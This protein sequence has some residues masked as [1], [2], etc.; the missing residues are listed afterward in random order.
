MWLRY[1]T[2]LSDIN[3]VAS[4]REELNMSTWNSHNDAE[5]ENRSTQGETFPTSKHSTTNPTQ[6]CLRLKQVP[7]RWQPATNR[8]SQARLGIIYPLRT[9]RIGVNVLREEVIW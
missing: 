6:I 9:A 7:W 3:I 5:R 4:V 2:T 1:L 8:L